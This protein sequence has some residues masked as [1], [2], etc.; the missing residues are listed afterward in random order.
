MDMFIYW[1]LESVVAEGTSQEITKV[2][3]DF[4]RIDL[5]L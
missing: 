3:Y 2:D 5:L 1:D 4:R